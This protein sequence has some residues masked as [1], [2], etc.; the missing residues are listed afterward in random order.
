MES[1][2]RALRD[3]DRTAEA[4][5]ETCLQ[6][7][8]LG[9]NAA[10][11]VPALISL[12]N[13]QDEMLRDYAVTT[14]D[15][16]G[17]AARNALPALRRTAAKDTS[18]EIRELARSAIAKISGHATASEPASAPEASP[19]PEPVRPPARARVEPAPV[20]PEAPVAEP[21]TPA[22]PEAQA[23]APEAPAAE[24]EAPRA[25][26]VE[27]ARRSASTA[28]RPTLEVHPGRFFRWAAP[29]GWTGSE[30]ASGLT[31]T[32]PDGLM[33]VSSALFLGQSGRISPA[34]FTLAMLGRLQYG[35]MQTLTK[36][37]LP[38]Q[39]SG[40]DSPWK[41]QEL[42]LRYTVNNVPV[43][44]IWTT[45][46]LSMDGKYDAYILGYQ[47]IPLAF[48]RA[49]LWLASVAHSIVPTSPIPGA[50]SEKMLTGIGN[51]N[52]VIKVQGEG[53]DKLLLPSNRPLDHPALLE[54]WRGQGHSED[55][56]LKAQRNGMMGYETT[57]DPQTSRVFEMPLEAWDNVAGGYHNPLRSDEVLQPIEAGD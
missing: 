23:T 5:G 9:P 47:S 46:I 56:I 1:L 3:P 2:V 36:R 35:S 32:A 21:E 15:R 50:G 13:S 52:Y 34:E 51:V 28:G 43:R 16:I 24:P 49:K 7:M 42:E 10:P 33:Q 54:I 4:K 37:D 22:A 44:A 27:T 8:D 14:L 31:L 18:A 45:G 11:A 20:Q 25:R 30:S 12:L 55:R 53:N 38:D 26:P 19:E 41:V 40:L 39:P 48:D 17:P 57:R 29:I 6:L